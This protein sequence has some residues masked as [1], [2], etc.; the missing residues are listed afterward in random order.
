[1]VN[2]S[3][4]SMCGRAMTRWL[5]VTLVVLTTAG[6]CSSDHSTNPAHPEE[7]RELLADRASISNWTIIHH[8]DTDSTPSL[9]VVSVGDQN[10]LL[11]M[12]SPERYDLTGYDDVLVSYVIDIWAPPNVNAGARIGYSYGMDDQVL[13][14]NIY[15]F[16]PMVTEVGSF[17]GGHT[18]YICQEARATMTSNLKNIYLAVYLGMRRFPGA[19]DDSCIVAVDF[20]IYG[21]H[22]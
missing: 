21:V 5:L 11:T 1:M 7:S 18:R 20:Q 17:G 6:G 16:L 14:N 9:R 13:Q 8:D 19:G 15:P 22:R 12:F 10:V 4:D 2:G 3:E